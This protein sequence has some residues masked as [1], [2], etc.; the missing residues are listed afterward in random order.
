MKNEAGDL[1]GHLCFG[2]S[3]REG[4]RRAFLYDIIIEEKWSG[5]GIGK[6]HANLRDGGKGKGGLLYRLHVFSHNPTAVGLYL[7]V[8]V[9]TRFSYG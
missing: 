2:L 9:K 8:G 6:N 5:R 4:R 7:G 1:I 3:G